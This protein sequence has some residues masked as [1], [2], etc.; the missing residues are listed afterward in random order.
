MEPVNGMICLK[1]IS[2]RLFKSSIKSFELWHRTT[3]AKGGG[4]RTL[5][6]SS[7]QEILKFIHLF[8]WLE[9]MA[10]TG[11]SDLN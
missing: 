5:V 3:N 6:K 2:A 1:E 8:S 11:V 7:L 4:F 10:L 9:K